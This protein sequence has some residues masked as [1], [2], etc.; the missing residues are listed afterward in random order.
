M[1]KKRETLI[2]VI[3]IF[4]FLAGLSVMLYPTVSNWWNQ[5]I[6]MKAI[7]EYKETVAQLDEKEIDARIA[8]AREYNRKL[9]MLSAPFRNYDQ[10]EGYD[11]I[12]DI[13]GTG[14]MGYITI[15]CIRV[16]LPIYH[17]TD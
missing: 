14:I 15:P 3:L 7:V 8:E 17:G 5:R 16:E 6:Q 10:I 13:S 9:A 4:I 12:L 2:T 1:K 11:D